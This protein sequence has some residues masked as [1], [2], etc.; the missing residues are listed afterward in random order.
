MYVTCGS[1]V[2]SS[3]ERGVLD[4]FSER[5]LKKRIDYDWNSARITCEGVD[6]MNNVFKNTRQILS[7][8]QTQLQM[9][10]DTIDAHVQIL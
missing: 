6:N 7:K 9:Q 10:H 1:C 5:L 3:V 8:I 2:G 4:H